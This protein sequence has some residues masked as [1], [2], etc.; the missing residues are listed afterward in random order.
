M[1]NLLLITVL[2]VSLGLVGCNKNEV[3]IEAEGVS[4]NTNS[5]VNPQEFVSD[6]SEETIA[7]K[8]FEASEADLKA[9]LLGQKKFGLFFHAGWCPTCIAIDKEITEN[10]ETLPEDTVIAKVDYDKEDNLKREFGVTT[11]SVVITFDDKGNIIETLVSP[12]LQQIL[13]SLGSE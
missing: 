2:V 9:K 8:Y 7:S 1:K 10:L 6:L 4:N 5:N 11:Q 13:I 12:T 3:K